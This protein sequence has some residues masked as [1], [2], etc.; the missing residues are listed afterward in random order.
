M[1]KGFFGFFVLLV[2]VLGLFVYGCGGNGAE[3]PG[4]NGDET[5]GGDEEQGVDEEPDGEALPRFENLQFPDTVSGII[6]TFSG[7]RLN[8]DGDIIEYSYLGSDSVDGEDTDKIFFSAND[9]EFIIWITAD[10]RIKKVEKDGELLSSDLYGEGED[11]TSTLLLMPFMMAGTYNID[12]YESAAGLGYS[13]RQ[14]GSS[15]EKIGDLSATVYTMEIKMGPPMFPEEQTYIQ[16]IADLGDFQ[17]VV[18]I[19]VFKGGDEKSGTR[20]FEF[21]LEELSLR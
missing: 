1:K 16:R 17:M 3:E 20:E 11:L 19:D 2:L 12:D 9:E 13:F 18:G 6:N 5:P 4:A 10:E 21:V 14:V 15:K 7:Y 8:F